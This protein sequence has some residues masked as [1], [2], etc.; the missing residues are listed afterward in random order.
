MS[1]VQEVLVVFEDK[2]LFR[3]LETKESTSFVSVVL[4]GQFCPYPNPTTHK[5]GCP[6]LEFGAPT[7]SLGGECW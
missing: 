1:M 2:M 6:H 5:L 3:T 7:Y 4:T